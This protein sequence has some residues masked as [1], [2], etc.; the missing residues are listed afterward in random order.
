MTTK[1]ITNVNAVSDLVP[2]TVITTCYG[3]NHHLYN[4]LS[5][6]MNGSVKPD[7]VIIVNDD[8]EPER[9]AE[10]SLNIVK[11]P[12][13]TTNAEDTP[14]NQTSAISS[15][16]DFD[17]GHNR[18]IGAAHA[19]ND[20]L[21]FL[22]V[23][24]IVAPTFIEQL[25][26]KLAQYPNALIMGQPRYLTRPL[27]AK[28][29]LELQSGGLTS[30]YLNRLSVYNPYRDNFDETDCTTTNM[31]HTAIK[32][33]DDYGTFWSL[34]FAIKR[35]QFEHINGFDTQYTGYGAEDTDFAFTARK[36]AIDFYLTA[37][38]IYHQQHTVYRP[39]LNHLE[40]IIIN[41]NHFYKKW[42]CWPMG[43]WLEEFSDMGLIDWANEQSTPIALLRN[44]SS[45]ELA[46]AHYPDAAYV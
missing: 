25:S 18:N 24:C 42:Q 8:A 10:F 22:D 29:S 15:K 1:P 45:D 44:P 5:S 31:A 26:A 27:S 46:L 35:Q 7:E 19:T 12:T 6:L 34:C 13:T 4:L 32:Q 9:L 36:L 21:I 16:M 37:D 39:P 17:I 43:G 30:A 40:S 38:L 14:V 3:R 11:L 28:E 23:D 33:T 41:A 20:T 2:V